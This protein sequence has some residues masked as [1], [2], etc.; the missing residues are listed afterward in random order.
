MYREI[1][2]CWIYLYVYFTVKVNTEVATLDVT[3][4]YLCHMILVFV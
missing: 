3:K 4:L 2:M 1:T